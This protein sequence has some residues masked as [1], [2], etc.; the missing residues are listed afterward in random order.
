MDGDLVRDVLSGDKNLQAAADIARARKKA[1]EEREGKIARLKKHADD[2]AKLVGDDAMDVDEAIAAVVPRA[3]CG[4]V[5][6]VSATP[7]WM[8]GAARP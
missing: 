2:L 6:R 1:K 3:S 5:A 8:M 7:L 4:P